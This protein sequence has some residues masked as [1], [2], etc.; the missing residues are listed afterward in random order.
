MDD[1]IFYTGPKLVSVCFFI[2]S[3]I[4]DR[5]RQNINR[6]FVLAVQG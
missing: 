1:H 4:I 6:K 2:P 5:S 3:L